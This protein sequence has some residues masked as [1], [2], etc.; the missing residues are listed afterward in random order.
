[1]QT[2]MDLNLK[3]YRHNISLCVVDGEYYCELVLQD[4]FEIRI[5]L[6]IIPCCLNFSFC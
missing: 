2:A 5:D 3:I 6:Y 1:M 4:R